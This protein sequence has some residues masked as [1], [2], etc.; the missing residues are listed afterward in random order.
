MTKLSEINWAQVNRSL[1]EQVK[2]TFK[3]RVINWIRERI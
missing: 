1:T 2:P 3:Q